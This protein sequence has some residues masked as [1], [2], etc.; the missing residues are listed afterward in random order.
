MAY[1]LDL[2]SCSALRNVQLV[3]HV[4]LVWYWRSNGLYCTVPPVDIDDEVEYE[5]YRIKAHCMHKN[6]LQFLTLFVG[7]DSSEDMWLSAG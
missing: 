5:V 2:S 7:Y 3:F 1:K 6:K 4:S